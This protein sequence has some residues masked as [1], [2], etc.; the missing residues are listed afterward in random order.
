MFGRL[1]PGALADFG[2][3]AAITSLVD[4]WHRRYPETCFKVNLPPAEAGLGLSGT[5]TLPLPAASNL[6]LICSFAGDA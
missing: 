6:G 2:L 1:R 4:F 5:A 3:A